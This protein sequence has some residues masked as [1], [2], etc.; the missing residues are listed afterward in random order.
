MY[1]LQEKIEILADSAKYD[2][3]CS[4][5]GSNRSSKSG[6]L[7]DTS[8]CGI[9]HS[10]S[11]DGRCISLLKILYTN[12]CVY[13]CAYCVNRRSNDVRRASFTPDE[14]VMI[15]MEFY[16]RN[17]IEGLFLSSGV[18][19]SP[20]DTSLELLE[21]LRRLRLKEDF[22]GYIHVK[23]IPGSDKDFIRKLSFYAD[24]VSVNI[25]LP[26]EKSLALLAPNKN[27]ENLLTP[28][29][30]ILRLKEESPGSFPAGQSTQM[31]IG[32]T[33]DTDQR[34][35][36]LS[37]Y[38]YQRMKMKRVY[39]SAYVPVNSKHPILPKDVKSPLLHE[40]RL[41]QSDFLLRQYGF[42]VSELLDDLNPNLDL[43]LDPK[44]DWALRHP[45]VFPVELKKATKALLLRVPGIG[46][47]SA[48][49]I[50]KARREGSL[51]ELGLKRMGVVLKRAR[52]FVLID[53]KKLDANPFHLDTQSTMFKEHFLHEESKA[54]NK[55]E[56]LDF[57]NLLPGLNE[58]K[59]KIWT[60]S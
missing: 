23:S 55:P 53:G 25:E 4:S 22:N 19:K 44:L 9:C 7:G 1:T 48:R 28:M 49:R 39:Y 27:K 36:T 29:K 52:Y 31:I 54:L 56:Q 20:D 38:F 8:S 17:Y 60:I 15:V 58:P 26:S 21:I 40:H 10:W 43:T 14:I 51:T 5:S 41:Y 2:V 30:E 6:M 47:T 46:P 34:I 3:S 35:L 42:E 12:E 33:P 24:R 13:D 32:A 11:E 45:E 37:S 59:E 57:F 50:L 16:K 18:K